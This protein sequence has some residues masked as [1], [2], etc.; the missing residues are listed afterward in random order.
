MNAAHLVLACCAALGGVRPTLTIEP[1]SIAGYTP[2]ALDC[3]VTVPAGT[4]WV[5]NLEVVMWDQTGHWQNT[6]WLPGWFQP[7]G[8]SLAF[9]MPYIS[10]IAHPRTSEDQWIVRVRYQ[11][12]AGTRWRTTYAALAVE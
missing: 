6:A 4:A 11:D 5:T 7:S 12:Q 3:C 1:Q 10:G 8:Q 9:T 2:F